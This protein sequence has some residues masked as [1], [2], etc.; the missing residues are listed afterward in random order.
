[1]TYEERKIIDEHILDLADCVR[2]SFLHQIRTELQ[3]FQALQ[4]KLRSP[5]MGNYSDNSLRNEIS[6]LKKAVA[7]LE[8]DRGDYDIYV[9]C[10][11]QF[12]RVASE[13]Q[14]SAATLLKLANKK[15]DIK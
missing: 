7:C 12:L 3:Q 10:F 6:D 11:M 2:K 5:T 13:Y 1:M 14:L 15:L 9:K 4:D 8:K